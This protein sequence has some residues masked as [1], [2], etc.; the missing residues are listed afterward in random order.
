MH[1]IESLPELYNSLSDRA[2]GSCF[3]GLRQNRVLMGHLFIFSSRRGTEYAEIKIIETLE[4][5]LPH[6]DNLA[7]PFLNQKS[8]LPEFVPLELPPGAPPVDCHH[9]RDCSKFCV[10]G[11]L[12][13]QVLI[14]PSFK[15]DGELR[16]REIPV[17]HRVRPFFGRVHY[18]GVEQLE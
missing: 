2:K 4:L 13:R 12:Q 5:L 14:E 3:Y 7:I 8:R 18:T 11:H 17:L 16:E 9:L 15:M 6:L 1:S 10:S